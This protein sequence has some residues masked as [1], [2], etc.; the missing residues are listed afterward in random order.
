MMGII[1]LIMIAFSIAAVANC[2]NIAFAQ[3]DPTTGRPL[4]LPPSSPSSPSSA[5]NITAP[6]G[7]STIIGPAAGP[8]IVGPSSIVASPI[9]GENQGNVNTAI[10][11]SNKSSL[12]QHE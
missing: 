8:T 11:P 4:N 1:M 10:T 12:V 2:V 9:T 5:G 6:A 7:N 3:Y